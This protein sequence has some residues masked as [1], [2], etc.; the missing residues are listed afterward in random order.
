[1]QDPHWLYVRGDAPRLAAEGRAAVS[2]S[3]LEKLDV[4]LPRRRRCCRAAP[5]RERHR[6][7]REV[8][9][10]CPALHGAARKSVGFILLFQKG[11]EVACASLSHRLVD[12]GGGPE[13]SSA[14]DPQIFYDLFL[15]SRAWLVSRRSS[16]LPTFFVCLSTSVAILTVRNYVLLLVCADFL[17]GAPPLAVSFSIHFE[18]ML[19]Q[20][21]MN[22]LVHHFCGCVTLSER[23]SVP[24]SSFGSFLLAKID[25]TVTQRKQIS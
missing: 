21:T 18:S 1:M 11:H 2:A 6:E 5:S 25:F 23:T 3:V 24:C 13:T 9:E 22:L 15:R 10:R 7:T 16:S 4:A 12:D 14:S 20:L 19:L 8:P 17:K